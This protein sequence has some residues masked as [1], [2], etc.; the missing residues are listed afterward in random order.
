MTGKKAVRGEGKLAVYLAIDLG[1][2]GCRSILFDSKLTQISD[3]YQE[4]GL[5]TPRDRWVEQDAEQWWTLTLK[6]AKEAI[7]KA[8]L[9]AGEIKGI[10][11]SS[12][13]ITLVPVDS[14]LNP[15][16]H[17]ISWLDTRA[18]RQTR[19]IERDFGLRRIFTL[20]GKPVNAAY[21]LPKVLWL[22]EEMPKIY[23]KTWKF[24]MPM[25]FLIAKLAGSCVTDHTM[26]SGTLLYDIKN[27]VWSRE[28]LERYGL[29]EER[30]PKLRWSGEAA[31]VL[32]PEVAEE[33]GLSKDCVVAVGAQDQRCAS[34]GAGL[35]KGVMTISLG[36]SG[37]VC[38]YWNEARTEGD[39]R[40]GWSAYVEEGAWV[41]EGVVDTAA[42]CLRWVRD[43]MFP[44]CGYDL[45]NREAEEAQK[46]GGRVFFYPYL[47]GG[48]SPDY[49]TDAQG[50]FY[51]LNLACRRGDFA[52]AVM[53][54]VAFQ[55]RIILEAMEAYEDV[56]RM[57]L[58]G[59]GSRSS[60]WCRIFSNITGMEIL[61]PATAE[62]AGAGAAVLAGVAAGE[63][64]REQ[65]PSL[66]C[67]EIYRP[68]E[69]QERY[70][71][72][73]KQYRSL[74]YKLWR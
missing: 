21:F 5:I 73:Y 27:K 1:T 23:E 65:L 62:A 60:L 68:D 50:S 57:V 7:K 44:G 6:T 71:E 58:F 29:D 26:A 17:A 32:L 64:S 31:G 55:V 28:I 72:M 19:Q 52:L 46:R 67:G 48:C 63:F 20:T 61:I 18:E 39:T 45:I 54:G 42:A 9:P 69:R 4:Y 40:I 35:K 12:Q 25:D 14:G 38:K 56:H 11:V 13:G 8:G 41:T 66:G 30:L 15:L 36:T 22:K 74:E 70:E 49:Y 2:T 59:G 47:S 3:C 10:S 53:E 34:L 43:T 24:L 33:L 37:A 16:Y 51:G